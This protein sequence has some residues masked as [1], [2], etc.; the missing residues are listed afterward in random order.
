MTYVDKF[1]LN[2]VQELYTITYNNKETTYYGY[3]EEAIKYAERFIGDV[4]AIQWS[5]VVVATRYYNEDIEDYSEWQL[6]KY[7]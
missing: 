3:F 6:S 7:E 5:N 4:I 2:K 1:E